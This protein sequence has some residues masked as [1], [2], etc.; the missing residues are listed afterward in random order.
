M[1]KTIDFTNAEP[2]PDI[3]FAKIP[4]GTYNALKIKLQNEYNKPSVVLY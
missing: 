4:A 1:P 3:S 2:T